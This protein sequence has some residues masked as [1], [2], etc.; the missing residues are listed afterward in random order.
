MAEDVSGRTSAQSDPQL[1]SISA[2]N[3]NERST[4]R[5]P[6]PRSRIRTVV[7]RN[8]DGAAAAGVNGSAVP[9][10]APRRRS[11]LKC[12]NASSSGIPLPSARS[13]RAS[14]ADRRSVD[15]GHPSDESTVSSGNGDANVL[16]N[17][18]GGGERDSWVLLDAEGRVDASSPEKLPAKDAVPSCTGASGYSARSNTLAQENGHSAGITNVTR[19]LDSNVVP[20][21]V[22]QH[23]SKPTVSAN[24]VARPLPP[25]KGKPRLSV[26]GEG[27]MRTPAG[28]PVPARKPSPKP[29]VPSTRDS[30]CNGS[31]TRQEADS[32]EPKLD[33]ATEKRD[34]RKLPAGRQRSG[35]GSV[36]QR[37]APVRIEAT[38]ET[39]KIA[40][41]APINDPTTPLS[42]TTST[43]RIPRPVSSPC[44]DEPSGACSVS[45]DKICESPALGPRRSQNLDV[46]AGRP[47]TP[48]GSGSMIPMR[49]A[50]ELTATPPG[51]PM[52]PP[53]K[54]DTLVTSPNKAPC[55]AAK[56]R[57]PVAAKTT[58]VK[59]RYGTASLRSPR[60]PSG[61]IPS[62]SVRRVEDIL[63]LYGSDRCVNVVMGCFPLLFYFCDTIFPRLMDRVSY[64]LKNL[65][66][67]LLFEQ[68]LV[69]SYQSTER[70]FIFSQEGN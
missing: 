67:G 14:M 1:L 37:A 4:P 70:S 62:K 53:R 35:S 18:S 28:N 65:T 56:P 7:A 29:A 54:A 32:N 24:Q 58:G 64:F 25:P 30:Q 23:D 31:V 13:S 12:N 49:K 34:G 22:E 44:L 2:E 5:P 61:A 15:G 3:P 51:S 41:T 48:S 17:A 50:P 40:Q 52:T 59:P 63:I 46:A 9:A 55:V 42:P 33:S 66:P 69:L 11:T 57:P 39:E 26:L 60:S 38:S 10:V 8:D 6:V 20:G 27:R 43:S 45:K 47:R 16:R 19:D 68:G 21:G 36:P